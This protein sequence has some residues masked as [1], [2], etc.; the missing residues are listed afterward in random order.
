MTGEAKGKDNVLTV[1]KE[2]LDLK[3][4][5]KNRTL[6]K[7]RS[8]VRAIFS[9]YT[10][11]P[12]PVVSLIYCLLTVIC[13]VFFP[14]PSFSRQEIE[15]A[16][17]NLTASVGSDSA[18]IG[19][20][21]E[22]TLKYTLPEG[23]TILKPAQIKGLKELTVLDRNEMPGII[24]IRLLIDS[25]GSWRTGELSLVYQDKNGLEG[26]ISAD[27]ISLSVL[28]NLGEKPEEAQ[29]KPIQT[30]IPTASLWWT[31]QPWLL[32]LLVLLLI[33]FFLFWWFRIR[34][35]KR[36]ENTYE[37]P[38]YLRAKKELHEL[39]RQQIFEAGNLKLFYFKFSE[40]LRRYLEALRGF[41][42]AEF[43][44]EEIASHIVD[45]RDRNLLSLLR[46]ADLIKFA[47]GGTTTAKKEE[48]VRRALSYIEA[49]TPVSNNSGYGQGRNKK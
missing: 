19:S 23:A 44:T 27:P 3:S 45:D 38:F 6:R 17:S 7:R 49:T 33:G 34:G 4:G 42:A 12:I 25:L 28:S 47:N 32:V 29:L 21:V 46:Q 11:H 2:L 37:E 22:L 10:L 5:S 8:I 9:F 20:I 1:T 26:I 31:I 18:A 15:S 48:E 35:S 41:P 24:T 16:P 40:I 13:L 30:I 36:G 43:T 14:I 39:E